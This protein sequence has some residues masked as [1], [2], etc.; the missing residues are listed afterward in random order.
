VSSYGDW[1]SAENKMKSIKD[2]KEPKAAWEKMRDAEEESPAQ[3]KSD[4]ELTSVKLVFIDL[5][6]WNMVNFMVTAAIAA[7]PAIIILFLIG[8]AIMMTFG[9]FFSGIGIGR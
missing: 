5:P 3:N 2:D 7:I 8:M 4:A 6:F 1:S 9:A